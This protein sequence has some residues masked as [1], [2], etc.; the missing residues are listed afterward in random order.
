MQH[1]TAIP[2][3]EIKAIIGLGNP[4]PAYTFTRH[5]IGFLIV[6]ALADQSNESWQE[7]Q[8]MLLTQ[9]IIE[10]KKILLIK[11]MT[12]MNNSGEVLAYL[13]K[14][15]IKQDNILVIH[16]ELELPFGQTKL[17]FDGSAR[18]HNG[19]KSIIAHG[20]AN[21][22]RLRFGID[23]PIDKNHVPDYVLA[24]FSETKNLINAKIDLACNMVADYIKKQN[25]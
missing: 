1:N 24:K 5:N 9:I 15:G 23:R 16:D 25:S 3:L 2:N 12:Y 13:Q 22:L 6:D 4:G 7:K 14:Q 8:N 11:P 20:G 21:F 17:K 18:G 10:G 19:L